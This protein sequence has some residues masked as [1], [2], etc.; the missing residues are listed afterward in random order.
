MTVLVY[1]AQKHKI[2]DLLAAGP[3]TSKAIASSIG[4]DEELTNRVMYACAAYGGGPSNPVPQ[5][6]N[7]KPQTLNPKP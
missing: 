5:T 3:M 2:P 7:P 6:P 1:I 4:V